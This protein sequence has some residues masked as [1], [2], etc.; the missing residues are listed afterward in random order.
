MGSSVPV[1]GLVGWSWRFVMTRLD[2]W[3]LAEIEHKLVK[4]DGEVVRPCVHVT[5]CYSPGTL[6]IQ[7]RVV[8]TRKPPLYVDHV[9]LFVCQGD[10]TGVIPLHENTYQDTPTPLSHLEPRAYYLVIEGLDGDDWNVSPDL[11]VPDR[12]I[13]T[14]RGSSRRQMWIHEGPHLL[15]D[16]RALF[17][18][19]EQRISEGNAS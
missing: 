14:V 15:E 16:V 19:R 10:S 17:A 5:R 12:S 7:T 8:N 2:R 3:P 6:A 9:E 13:I 11:L 1:L 4:L 18:D